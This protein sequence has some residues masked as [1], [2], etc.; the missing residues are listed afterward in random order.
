MFEF[1]LLL[2]QII[3]FCGRPCIGT[4][5]YIWEFHKIIGF[6]VF[7]PQNV[8][9]M[10]KHPTMIFKNHFKQVGISPITTVVHCYVCHSPHIQYKK[11]TK[12]FSQENEKDQKQNEK[13]K[14][15]FHS[16]KNHKRLCILINILKRE[17]KDENK[18]QKDK[19][20]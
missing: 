13:G 20:Q 11:N 1:H 4:H 3:S 18:R 9:N 7:Q 19:R 10:M 5:N 2:D 14:T 16:Q 6:L 12:T 17:P 8:R 15:I